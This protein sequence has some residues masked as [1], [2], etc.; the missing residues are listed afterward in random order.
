MTTTVINNTICIGNTKA[1]IGSSI[2]YD[3]STINSSNST[4]NNSSIITINSSN[5]STINSNN[6]S[7][8]QQQHN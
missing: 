3:S 7:Y 6:S 2:K 8:L 1:I 4:I 5:S